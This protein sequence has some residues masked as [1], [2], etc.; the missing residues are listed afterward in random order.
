MPNF[1]KCNYYIFILDNYFF[2]FFLFI[3]LLALKILTARQP[4]VTIFIGP[5]YPEPLLLP[6]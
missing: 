3:F 6:Q 1:V 2:M 5:L 4:N